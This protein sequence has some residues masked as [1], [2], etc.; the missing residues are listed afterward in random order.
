MLLGSLDEGVDVVG[1]LG[2]ELAAGAGGEPLLELR[3]LAVRIDRR[4]PARA[5]QEAAALVKEIVAVG[6]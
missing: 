4:R 1:L 5:Q 2:E 6:R 3:E